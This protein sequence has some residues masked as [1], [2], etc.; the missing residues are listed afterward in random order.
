MRGSIT[1]VYK[2]SRFLPSGSGRILGHNMV[3][4]TAGIS[5]E[6]EVNV[7]ISAF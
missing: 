1:T 2:N 3:M 5:V 4:V 7:C 6:G